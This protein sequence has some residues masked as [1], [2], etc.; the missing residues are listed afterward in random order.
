MSKFIKKLLLEDFF[1]RFNLF[2]LLLWNVDCDASRSCGKYGE[3]P[4]DI[5][6]YVPSPKGTTPG[7]NFQ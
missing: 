2:Q 5:K 4:C 7:K 6:S 3:P 1:M